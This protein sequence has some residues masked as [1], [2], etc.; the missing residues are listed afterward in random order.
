MKHK[1]T[2]GLVISLFGLLLSPWVQAQN[3]NDDHQRGHNRRLGPFGPWS[4][5]VNLGPAIN[6]E[7]N[8]FGPSISSDGLS[9]YFQSSRPGGFGRADIYVSQRASGDDP[10]GPPEDLG[11]IVNATGPSIFNGYPNLSPDGHQLF[12]CS[13]R[14]GGSAAWTFGSHSGSTYVTTLVG[15][16]R[17]TWAR[18]STAPFDDCDPN[19]FVDRETGAVTLYFTSFNRPEGIGDWD[20]YTSTLGDDGA[21]GPA[22]LVREIDTPFRETRPAIRRD[23]LELIFSS[24]RP[25]SLGPIDLWVSTRESTDDP[26]S[27]PVNLGPIV[28]I[29]G[30]T[31]RS[32]GLSADGTTLYF[33]SD[34][35]GGFRGVDIYVST[36][37]RL[38]DDDE[39]DG[40]SR[41]CK[42]K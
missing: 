9:L 35:P 11:P 12:I 8:D 42:D 29:A 19:P 28:N 16:R 25:G 6:T 4:E 38:C 23:G 37:T 22:S 24:N 15:K 31:T 30:F 39:G 26:W 32:P 13:D 21:F 20:L 5:P 3:S 27:E 18:V 10:W 36:R 40:I 7:F 2:F 34:R 33:G 1:L 17:L 41:G 14:P